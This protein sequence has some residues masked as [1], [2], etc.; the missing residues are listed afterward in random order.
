MSKEDIHSLI[1]M[2]PEIGWIFLFLCCSNY[3]EVVE[4]YEPHQFKAPSERFMTVLNSLGSIAD[5]V[6]EVKSKDDGIKLPAT[7]DKYV[8]E[9]VSENSS[10]LRDLS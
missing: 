1:E 5:T 8:N 3:I 10:K 7:L 4:G 6:K 9:T 2:V